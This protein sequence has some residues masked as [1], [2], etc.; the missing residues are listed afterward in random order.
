MTKLHDEN[1]YF[2]QNDLLDESKFPNLDAATPITR[3]PDEPGGPSPWSGSVGLRR[4]GTVL[5]RRRDDET[6]EIPDRP[7]PPRR[8]DHPPW[9]LPPLDVPLKVGAQ[10]WLEAV[11]SWQ[12]GLDELQ[13]RRHDSAAFL[14]GECQQFAI[15]YFHIVRKVPATGAD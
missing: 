3:A 7:E 5:A 2:Y 15:E 12:R 10:S 13:R 14:F 11:R 1:F 8:P 4:G 6:G 9:E